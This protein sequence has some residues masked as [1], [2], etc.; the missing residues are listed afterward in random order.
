VSAWS[1]RKVLLGVSA[2]AVLG[3]V[4]A[5]VLGSVQ[6]SLLAMAGSLILF[7]VNSVAY[8]WP[9]T[10][11]TAPTAQQSRNHQQVVAVIT[12]DN[13]ATTFTVTHNW[14]LTAAELAALFPEV[15]YEAILAAGNTAAPVVSAR[16][17]NSVDFTCTAFTGAGLVV[18]IRRP[19]TMD[20]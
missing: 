18:R 8:E 15:D 2:V 3:I 13:A 5:C 4:A 9:I 1:V 14:G 11:A 17:A 16:N 19:H 10:G 12:G 6:G 7:G 20:R